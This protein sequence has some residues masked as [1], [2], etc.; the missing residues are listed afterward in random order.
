MLSIHFYFYTVHGHD[1]CFTFRRADIVPLMGRTT[2]VVTHYILEV[3]VKIF[4]YCLLSI[5]PSIWTLCLCKNAPFIQFWW[6][7][8]VKMDIS[9]IT[10]RDSEPWC[11]FMVVPQGHPGPSDRPLMTHLRSLDAWYIS[12]F[13]WIPCMRLDVSETYTNIFT[14]DTGTYQKSLKTAKALS[15]SC[16]ATSMTG[17]AVLPLP[18]WKSTFFPVRPPSLR[19]SEH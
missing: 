19:R 10:V 16:I 9:G 3:T 12:P 1:S 13:I 5:F 7:S 6:H 11:F 17:F 4:C 14:A 2:T 15:C 18:W 8:D